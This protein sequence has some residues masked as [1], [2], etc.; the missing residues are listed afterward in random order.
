MVYFQYFEEQ[1][2][3]GHGALDVTTIV[4]FFYGHFCGFEGRP[5]DSSE[6]H[7]AT[8]KKPQVC[9]QGVPPNH[10]HHHRH[11]I[12]IV[13]GATFRHSSSTTMGER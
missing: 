6:T 7:N 3:E 1:R 8:I 10:H 4:R 5:K 2:I 11:N 13:S 9:L 12:I